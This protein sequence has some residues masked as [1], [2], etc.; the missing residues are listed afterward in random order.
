MNSEVNYE[1]SNWRKDVVTCAMKYANHTWTPTSKN[2]C[3]GYDSEG[4]FINTPDSNYTSSK[5]NCGRWLIDQ[6]NKGIPYNWGGCSTIDDFDA[7]IAEG[8]YA[9]NVPDSRDNG[10]SGNCIGLDCSGLVTICWRLTK[11]MST[12][13]LPT[14]AVPLDS[15][16]LLL[17]GDIILLPGSHVMIFINFTDDIKTSAQIIDAT[18]KTGRVSL[19]SVF[20]SDLSING[21]AGYRKFDE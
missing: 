7:G 10:V 18:R 4:L 8:K 11:K 20:L 9:G 2:A 13:T 15:M 21:Y 17:P 5:Y 19:R 12:R 6:V 1:N 14:V 3:H 16:D